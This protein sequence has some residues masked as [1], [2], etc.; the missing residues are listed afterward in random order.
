MKGFVIEGEWHMPVLEI[1]AGLIMAAG[2]AMVAAAKKIVKKFGLDKK[3]T[4][5]H[6][7][8]LDESELEEYRM[9]KATVNVKLYGMLVFLP[10]VIL[11]LIA[12]NRM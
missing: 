9:L 3:V 12:F 4:T 8:E 2:V 6:E 1:L 7:S 5:E 10:G 11:L